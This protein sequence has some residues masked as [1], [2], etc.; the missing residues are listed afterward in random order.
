MFMSVDETGSR[1][2][3]LG[4]IAAGLAYAGMPEREPDHGDGR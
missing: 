3:R 4:N 2:T 1:R